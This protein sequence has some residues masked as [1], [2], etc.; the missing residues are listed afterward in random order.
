MEPK[1]V[2]FPVIFDRLRQPVPD[3]ISYLAAWRRK[4][5]K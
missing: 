2:K 1:L 4:L 3:F 5:N